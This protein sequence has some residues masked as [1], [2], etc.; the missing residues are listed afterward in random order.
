MRRRRAVEDD[1]SGSASAAK[2]KK[3][4]MPTALA[5]GAGILGTLL[6]VNLTKS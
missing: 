5:V 4:W 1:D 2:H 6:I 3:D